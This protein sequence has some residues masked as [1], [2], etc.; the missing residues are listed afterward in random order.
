MNKIYSVEFLKEVTNQIID[1]KY[2]PI[3]GIG[4]ISKAEK[5]AHIEISIYTTEYHTDKI[6]WSVTEELIPHEFH[7]EISDVLIFFGNYLTALKGRREKNLVFEIID[8]SFNNDSGRGAFMYA[9][10][11]ALVGCF[12]KKIEVTPFQLERINSAKNNGFNTKNKF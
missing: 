12:D 1:W 10:V 7:Q 6:E 11:R 4:V 3:T 2:E 8:G 9:T 5:Y